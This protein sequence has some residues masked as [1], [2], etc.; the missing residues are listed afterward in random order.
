M[1]ENVKGKTGE[2][3]R[4]KATGA[5]ANSRYASQLPKD[6]KNLLGQEVFSFRG[7]IIWGEKRIF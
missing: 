6:I 2:S 5:K 3:R 1:R 7:K 4:R